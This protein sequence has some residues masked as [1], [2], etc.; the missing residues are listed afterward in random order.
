VTELKL[1]KKNRPYLSCGG[2]SLR[3]FFNGKKAHGFLGYQ[4]IEQALQGQRERHR[5]MVEE[6]YE[7]LV[8]SEEKARRTAARKKAAKKSQKAANV[9]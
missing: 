9:T 6:E 3:I 5:S 1:D 7:S 8:L 4:I 2:C